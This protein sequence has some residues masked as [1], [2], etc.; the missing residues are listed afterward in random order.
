VTYLDGG[1][2]H[3]LKSQGCVDSLNL[4]YDQQFL[5]SCLANIHA[6]QAVTAA[7]QAYLNAGCDVITSNSF[8]ATPHHVSKLGSDV[9]YLK[10]VAVRSLRMSRSHPCSVTQCGVLCWASPLPAGVCRPRHVA[11]ERRLH[12]IF[13][14]NRPKEDSL[15][16]RAACHHCRRGAVELYQQVCK[17]P[18]RQLFNWL[19]PI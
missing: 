8:V 6:P 18:L 2:G 12:A 19:W 13:A 1:M 11:P 17:G 3:L 10:L 5:S 7:H 9:D 15:H 4:P 16:L 14:A